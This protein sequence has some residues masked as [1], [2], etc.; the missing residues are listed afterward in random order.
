MVI[1][2]GKERRDLQIK[3]DF[4]NKSFNYVYFR[5]LL[6]KKSEGNGQNVTDMF[7]HIFLNM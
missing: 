4:I 7:K 6:F 1:N 3:K 2:I 5:Y